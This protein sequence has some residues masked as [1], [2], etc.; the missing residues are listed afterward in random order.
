M[1]FKIVVVVL[2]LFVCFSGYSQPPLEREHRI[3]KSQF[4]D[5]D[6]AAVTTPTKKVRYY[7]EIDTSGTTYTVK[8]K[9]DRLTYHIAMDDHARIATLGFAVQ[10][11]DIPEETFT[12]ITAYLTTDFE[13]VKV[14]RILQR[15]PVSPSEPLEKTIKNTFQNLMLPNTLYVFTFAGKKDNTRRLYEVTFD[16]E[17]NFRSLKHVLPANHDHVLY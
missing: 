9:K 11:V 13:K 3:R 12:T 16:A 7:R 10:E 14:K 15:Y 8:F 2:L 5:F 17:G 1:K 6:L 4:P